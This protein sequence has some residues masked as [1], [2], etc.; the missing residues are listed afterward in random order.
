MLALLSCSLKSGLDVD[1]SLFLGSLAAAQSVESISN[2]V[3]VNKVQ[4][5]KTIDH[6]IK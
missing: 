3:P 6:V 5:L 4:L 2:S 1:L